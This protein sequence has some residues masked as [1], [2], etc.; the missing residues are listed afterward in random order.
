MSI[1]RRTALFGL[2]AL[3]LSACVG[4]SFKTEYDPLPADV[5]RAWRL[6]A[7][8][9]NVPRTLV[10]SEAKTLLPKADIVWR[11]DPLGDRYAQVDTIMTDAI[12]RG[13]QGLRGGRP[14]IIDVTVTRFHAL[15]FE[16]EL[17]EQ[18]WGVH[19]INFTAQVVDARTGEVLIPATAIRSELPALSGEQM[20]E[21]RRNGQSQKSMIT[22]HVAR[23]VAGWLAIGPDNR[24]E[25]SRQGN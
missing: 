22:N 18:N 16:A 3:L 14:V 10:V 12:T 8:Q 9:V 23:T 19:N 13:A 1:V 17:R 4:G 6:S 24:G 21:A 25:F 2:T 20:R 11:E 15:T 5:T 7:V